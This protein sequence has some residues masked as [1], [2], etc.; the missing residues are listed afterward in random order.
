MS[1]A[2]SSSSSSAAAAAGAAGASA[3]TAVGK[4]FLALA[5]R[6]IS[7]GGAGVD[8]D[9]S[10]QVAWEDATKVEFKKLRVHQQLL[11]TKRAQASA[12]LRDWASSHQDVYGKVRGMRYGELCLIAFRLG[13]PLPQWPRTAHGNPVAWGN[14]QG[15]ATHDGL[16]AAITEHISLIAAAA[17]TKAD[18]PVTV[19]LSLQASGGRSKA[20]PQERRSAS[21]PRNQPCS[22]SPVPHWQQGGDE[23]K[24]QAQSERAGSPDPVP[25][26]IRP[27]PASPRSVERRR[28][29][30][31]IAASIPAAVK[32]MLLDIP[33]TNGRSARDDQVYGFRQPR[34]EA[35]S[36]TGAG[37]NRALFSRPISPD[38]SPK[39][40]C[41]D[42]DK[43][44]RRSSEKRRR[45]CSPSPSPSHSSDSSYRGER[46]KGK[47]ERSGRRDRSSSSSGSDRSS[48]SSSSSSSSDRE[49]G[50]YRR[51][52]RREK[53]K[54]ERAKCGSSRRRRYSRV[55]AELLDLGIDVAI[56][57]DIADNVLRR[58][59]SFYA[60]AAN[61][62]FQSLRNRREAELLARLIDHL[63]AGRPE[64]AL[65]L[66]ARR[67]A[68]VR[69]ADKEGNW[70]VCDALEGITSREA[71]LPEHAL[72]S[73]AKRVSTL[74]TFAKA[75][76]VPSPVNG[77]GGKGGRRGGGDSR[78]PASS[79]DNSRKRG[80][81]SNSRKS[82][83]GVGS[84]K[85]GSSGGVG[86][87]SSGA[88][89]Q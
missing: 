65:E 31:E 68:G 79:R 36:L 47:P 8:I 42:K 41:R 17:P 82:G 52:H 29:A 2:H 72:A 81:G 85:K 40:Q 89:K 45:R 43:S 73:I 18:A 58:G 7:E 11:Q 56:A 50:R 67:F 84:N 62:Q 24:E 77:A 60:V 9:D 33:D 80:G 71:D 51:R 30:R 23:H 35:A 39:A 13:I 12:V 69:L 88:S 25:H 54:K 21:V 16:A 14:A 5:K 75:T 49:D 20:A 53:Q 10:Q 61:E 76:A 83:S 38:A 27:T 34:K 59:P 22:S 19:S 46:G 1:A 32:A 74:A 87:A 44:S 78:P 57:Q 70:T 37:V 64:V 63:R 6:P 48:S 86:A 4:S 15:E 3:A 28:R 26:A 55:R 66:A